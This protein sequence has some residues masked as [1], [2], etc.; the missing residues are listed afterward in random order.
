MTGKLTTQ[1]VRAIDK[2]GRYLDGAGLYLL[3]SPGGSKSWV[4]RVRIGGNRT[5]K[6][7]GGF[8][9][10][11]LSEA[12]KA[13][14]ANKAAV[15]AGLNPWE[16]AA[17]PIPVPAPAAPATMPT[18]AEALETV[19]HLNVPDWGEQTAKRWRARVQRH[20]CPAVGDMRID[21]ITR[22]DLAGILSPL[23]ATQWETARKLRQALGRIFRWARAHDYI[24]ADPADDALMELVA[25][26]PHAPVHRESLPYA[27]VPAA[28]RRLQR[29]YGGRATVLA[30]EFLI[31]TAARTGEV[32]GARWEEFDLEAGVWT[33]PASRMKGRRE[34]RI[35]LSWRAASIIRQM[36]PYE[37]RA[38]DDP[39]GVWDR[40]VDNPQGLV[41]RHPNGKHLSE[42]AFL[43]RCRKD[44]LHC[45]PHGFRT[46]FRDWAKAEARARFE[47]IELC[48]AHAVGSSVTQAYD[49]DD[50]LDE[51]R[52]LMD[53]WAQYVE[54]V[55]CPF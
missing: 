43:N 33:I 38:E 16:K 20:A 24:I 21:E 26:V 5:D 30:F 41:F 25:R 3:V 22:A 48:L 29:G 15:K 53:A 47:A 10:V 4:Q 31:Y 49:R 32:R 13:A 17:E 37:E 51:R 52:E 19:Y 44:G 8:P 55:D 54:R 35:P 14:A 42:N 46:S 23:R 36:W 11:S 9:R 2:P 12:R 28:I 45:T 6:G 50:L 1:G 34:H 39:D 7:L 40:L 27:E 18:F